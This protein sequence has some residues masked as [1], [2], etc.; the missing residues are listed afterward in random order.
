MNRE[1]IEDYQKYKKHRTKTIVAVMTAFVLL[2]CGMAG[3]TLAWLQS[4]TKPVVNTFSPSN[5]EVKLEE[6]TGTDYKMVPGC[7]IDKNPKAWVTETSEDCYLFIKV[8]KSENF[9]QYI[10]YAID[11]QW[12]LLDKDKY[13]DIYYICIDQNGKKG[14]DAGTNKY[15]ILGAGSKEYS[16]VSY[17]WASN[18]VLVKPTVTKQMMD[19]LGN[20]KPTLTFTA[21]AVQLYKDNNTKFQPKEAWQI[22][23][24]SN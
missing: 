1:R 16:N 10:D 22:A 9:D 23:Q 13:P 8:E 24:P 18:Q 20:N 5:I 14:T 17:H 7:V 21:Y 6:T 12:T 11:G 19:G 4:E 3:T 2:V 15:N